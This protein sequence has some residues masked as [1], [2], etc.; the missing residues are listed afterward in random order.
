MLGELIAYDDFHLCF[1]LEI[2]DLI[3]DLDYKDLR[4]TDEIWDLFEI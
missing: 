1:L 4:F 2:W 3:S